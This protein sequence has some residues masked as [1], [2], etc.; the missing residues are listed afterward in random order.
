MLLVETFVIAYIVTYG[1]EKIRQLLSMEPSTLD[2]KWK[3]WVED[4]KW[5]PLD[6]AGIFCFLLGFMLRYS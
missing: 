1:M 5:H 3:V 2:Q 6:L 4:S